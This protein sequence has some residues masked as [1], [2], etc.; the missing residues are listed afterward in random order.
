MIQAAGKRRIVIRARAP[1]RSSENN[2]SKARSSAHSG[3]PGP[4]SSIASS[5]RSPAA[6]PR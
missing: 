5:T 4:L 1:G 2:R 3:T 6:L